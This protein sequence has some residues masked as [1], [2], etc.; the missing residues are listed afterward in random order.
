M[1]AD[2]L[3]SLL[4]PIRERYRTSLAMLPGGPPSSGAWAH[5]NSADDVPGLLK[6]VEAAL[7]LADDWDTQGLVLRAGVHEDCAR[8]LRAAIT[9]ALA[10]EE[11]SDGG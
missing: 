4:S 2:D 5:V 11:A 10:G 6:A 7:K 3:S 9:T 8:E 1:S